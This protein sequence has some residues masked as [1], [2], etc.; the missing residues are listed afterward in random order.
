M[1]LKDDDT[2]KVFLS[3]GTI[4]VLSILKS[5]YEYIYDSIESE[6]IILK[7]LKCNLFKELIFEK[8]VVGFCSYDF[9]SEFMTAALNNVYVLPQYRGNGLFLEELERTMVQ[10]NKPSIVEPTRLVVELLIAY[11]FAQIMDEGIVASSLEFIVPAS[12]VLSNGDIEDE[13]LSTHFYDLNICAS[14]HFLDLES[15]RIAYSAPLNYDIIHYDCLE[16]RNSIGDEYFMNL[17]KY[18]A[19]DTARD[20]ISN[21]EESLPV[22]TYTIEEVLGDGESFSPYLESLIDDGH[23]T[24][25]DAYRIKHQMAEEYERGLIVDESLLIRLA[26]LFD[27]KE[28]PKI[29]SHSDVC[30]Y[31]RMPTDSHDRF[32]HFCGINLKKVK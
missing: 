32:C 22:K 26:Y 15:N 8:K 13:E 6:G 31:C 7:G 19:D 9:S 5:D 18:F 27:Q 30:P 12:H 14:I 2:Q 29:K 4:D 1:I 25:D 20:I 17:Q 23:I 3:E 24:C 10:Y 16:K 11:G 21:L 28:E